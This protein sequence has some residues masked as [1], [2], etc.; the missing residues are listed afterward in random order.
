[1]QN[2]SRRPNIVL[3]GFMGTGKST[4]G[5]KLAD[6]LHYTFID[7]DEEIVRQE[8]RSIPDI[9]SQDGEDYFRDAESRALLRLLEQ[10]RVVVAT[11]GGCVLRDP[12]CLHMQ[13][14]G[15]VVQLTAAMETIVERV[16]GDRNRPLLQGDV[17]ERVRLLMQA[18]DGKYDFAHAKVAT[19]QLSTASIVDR[20]ESLYGTYCATIME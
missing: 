15:Y 9:F 18:R 17:G 8:G 13:Q 20:I 14:F 2:N 16:R 12:N 10:D 7:L 5:A 3:I 19:D 1:M 11:G 6:S 4:V